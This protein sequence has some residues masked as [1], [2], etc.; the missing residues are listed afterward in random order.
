MRR[1]FDLDCASEPCTRGDVNLDR[2]VDGRDATRFVEVLFGGG[3][4]GEVCAGDLEPVPDG[5]I[6]VGDIDSFV[7]CLIA[8]GC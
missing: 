8:G 7:S 5:T 4:P 6:D 1:I 2:G 3:S